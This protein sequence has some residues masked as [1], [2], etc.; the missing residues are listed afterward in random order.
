MGERKTIGVVLPTKDRIDTLPEAVE[1]VLRQTYPVECLVVVDDASTDGTGDY[2]D[3]LAENDRR[4]RVLRTG[5]V[6]AGAARNIGVA[7][8]DTDLIA[9]QD[10]D[11]SWKPEFLRT[12][13]TLSGP[14]RVV[15][16]SHMLTGLD[17]T[18]ELVPGRA[19]L[20]PRRAL[21]RT[22]VAST[23]TVLVDRSLLVQVPFDEALPRFQ[24]WDLWL[25]LLRHE[26]VEFHHVPDALVDIRRQP[27]SISES[28]RRLRGVALRRIVR[29]HWRVF[30]PDPYAVV[31][32]LA[33]AYL[34]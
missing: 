23:Q 10:S 7:A 1:S 11:D 31:R 29:K 14:R 26:D 24:D 22:N 32:V 21:R 34:R 17:G 33:R 25:S 9:F 2:L 18:T 6:G 4:V 27:S 16:S 5:G 13:V 12:L 19:V 3:A 30:A 15:F 28:G 8:C 20:D